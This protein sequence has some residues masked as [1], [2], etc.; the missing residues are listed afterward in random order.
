MHSTA[1]TAEL[2]R[3]G[4]ADG[5]PAPEQPAPG[6]PAAGDRATGQRGNSAPRTQLSAI[7]PSGHV[8]LGNYLGAVRRWAAEQR[9]G[10]QPA[11]QPEA[12]QQDAELY[13]VSDLHAMT[14]PHRPERLRSLAQEQLAVLLAA[15]LAPETVFVQSDLACELGALNWVLECVCTHGEAA[16][17]VQFKEKSTGTETVRLGLL[18]YPVLMAADILAQG[19]THVPVGEDQ[20]QHVEL[21][22]TLAR[23]FNHGHG[24]VF[25]VPEP[26]TPRVGARVG[27]LAD[28]DR[29]MA[30]SAQQSAGVVFVLDDPDA[31]RRKF[32]RAVTDDRGAVRYAPEQQ[33]GVSNL[34]EILG[35]CQGASPYAAA[36]G[37]SSY[38]Q[39][40]DA[41]A[42]AVV[43]SLQPVRTRA[44]EL[45]ADPGELARVRARGAERARER[46]RPRLDAALRLAGMGGLP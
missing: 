3:S 29:K 4:P 33:P 40:K 5:E 39:L 44:R 22:R 28:P 38:A 32:R 2:D 9:T 31:I 43:E 36:S 41:T 16:R 10:S 46:M 15:G 14:A 26:V 37:I 8:Q 45:L 18:T 7:T 35:A 23:R 27:D 6:Q 25:A 1:H 20:Q 17:M 19:T 13:F 21:A 42:E 24:A 12:A 34:L 30:K 11:A